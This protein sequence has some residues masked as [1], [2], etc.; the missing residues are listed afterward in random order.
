[1]V[2]RVIDIIIALI[3]LTLLLLGLPVI[4]FF[5]KIDSR[6]PVFY[7]CDRVGLNGKVFKMYKFR[8]MYENPVNLGPSLSPLGDPRVTPVGKVLRRLKLNEFPQFFNVLKGDM[9]LIGPR[10]ESLDLA[11]AYPEYAKKI[12]T[13]KPGLMGPNQILGRNEEEMYPPGGDP[14][15]FYLEQLLPRKVAI[16]L[17]YIDNKSV[18]RDLKYLFLGVKVT[19]TEAISRRHLIDNLS[20][21]F[22]LGCDASLCVL[23]FS[24]ALYI[25]FG[26]ADQ[27]LR[28]IGPFV[29]VL[30]LTVL[31]R[32]PIFIYFGFYHTLIRH[33]SI[34]DI[35]R[36]IKGVT[37]GSLVLVVVIFLAGFMRG[38]SRAVFMI[39]WLCLTSLLIGYRTILVT[40]HQHYVGKTDSPG[41]GKNVLIWGAGDAGELCLRYLQKEKGSVYNIV[42]FIDDNPQ[43][44]GKRIRGVKILGNRH[45][46]ELVAKLYNIQGVFIAI[47]SASENEI[48]TILDL[49]VDLGL[50]ST[51]FLAK[52]NAQVQPAEPPRQVSLVN[53]YPPWG[54]AQSQKH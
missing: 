27:P 37:F 38:Y 28:Y 30:P 21:L 42:G 15:K 11:Q 39:D 13:V 49:C 10:P 8:T 43:K 34:Y 29:K 54:E 6:G 25:R 45:H 36:V 16:D 17:D 12:F 41:N 44:R 4:A 14:V 48:N 1:M 5:I 23:S 2:T 9:S 7:K 20:Q 46:L 50:G 47:P 51:I 53:G 18:L 3:G 32:M 22:M 31:I 24:L 19:V 40:L 35:K 52:S 33:L 26:N